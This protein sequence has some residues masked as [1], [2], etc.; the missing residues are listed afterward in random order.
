ML[1]KKIAMI[2][3]F[4]SSATGSVIRMDFYDVRT[5]YLIVF[6]F[7]TVISLIIL[8]LGFEDLFR[9]DS[10]LDYTLSVC[11]RIINHVSSFFLI[12]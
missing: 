1:I 11:F 7:G 5:S 6:V 2:A 8:V 10:Y 12:H 4:T 3:A 9:D